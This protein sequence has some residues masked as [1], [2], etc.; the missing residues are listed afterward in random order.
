[1]QPFQKYHAILNI[2]SSKSHTSQVPTSLRLKNVRI[3][4]WNF[5]PMTLPKKVSTFSL[6]NITKGKLKNLNYFRKGVGSLWMHLVSLHERCAKKEYILLENWEERTNI[7]MHIY[8]YLCVRMSG[9]MK[10]KCVCMCMCTC[11]YIHIY[12]FLV[13]LLH[14]YVNGLKPGIYYIIRY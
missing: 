2:N 11:V 4:I 12:I 6:R 7:Y 3:C 1:M 8:V 9:V 10:A 14:E 5:I 13:L